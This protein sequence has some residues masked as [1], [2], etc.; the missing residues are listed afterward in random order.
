MWISGDAIYLEKEHRE[1]TDISEHVISE[2]GFFFF[3][4]F[5]A[6]QLRKLKGFIFL[7][8]I[9]LSDNKQKS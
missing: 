2:A 3:F 7:E 1:E 6:L 5:S 9:N 8:D 4:F